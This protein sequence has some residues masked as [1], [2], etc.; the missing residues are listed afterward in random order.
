MSTARLHLVLE[1]LAHL[2]QQDL[3][4]IAT[5]HGLALAQLEALQFLALANRFSDTP[6][7]LAEYL[8]ATRGTVS[9]TVT[10]LERKGLVARV[11]DPTDRRV[12][13]C[14]I[15]DA[16]RRLVEASFP[17][18]IL[19]GV[20][21]TAAAEALEGLLVTLVGARGGATFGVCRSCAHFRRA[22]SGAWCGLVDQA[23]TEP[24]TAALCREHQ[25]VG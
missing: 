10:A 15:T 19:A 7:T 11:T 17:A 16:G 20:D 14:A 12:Q 25:P 1:R 4:A 8:G 2:V 3:R 21:G 22:A 24:E 6:S 9:Q 23:L 13:H 5:A 18:P